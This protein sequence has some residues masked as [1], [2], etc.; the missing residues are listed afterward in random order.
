R[1]RNRRCSK[2][3]W[4]PLSQL[5][6][7]FVLQLVSQLVLQ[8]SELKQRCRTWLR[9][10][11]RPSLQPLSEQALFVWHAGVGQAGRHG[12]SQATGTIRARFT[13]T[14]SGTQTSTRLVTV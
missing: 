10:Q 4:Q 5:V 6:V 13:H 11:R 14:V 12:A 7:Q 8:L 2:H 3:S 1:L 9:R